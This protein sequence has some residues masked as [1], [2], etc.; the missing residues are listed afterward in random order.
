LLPAPSS[1]TDVV[2]QVHLKPLSSGRDYGITTPA[3]LAG[4]RGATSG[5]SRQW[6]SDAPNLVLRPGEQYPDEIETV[7]ANV[8]R[9]DSPDAARAWTRQGITRVVTPV[10]LTITGPAPSDLVVV[11]GLGPLA[12]ELDYLAVFTEGDTAF[13]LQMVA[14]GSGD[15][16]EQ[17]ARL[18]KDWTVLVASSPGPPT[19]QAR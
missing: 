17:F 16:D 6:V 18:V 7:V 5:V 12:G 9:F 13:T 14:G 3:E 15:H 1:V 11:R 8:V 10:K 19:T 4:A 2:P